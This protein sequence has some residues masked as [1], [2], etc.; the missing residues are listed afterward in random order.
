MSHKLKPVWIRAT[1]RSDNDFH[2]SHEVICCSNL[3]R[4]RVAAIYRI[5]SRPLDLPHTNASA[6]VIKNTEVKHVPRPALIATFTF[7]STNT[8]FKYEYVHHSCR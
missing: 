3:S 8:G 7:T 1:D 2:M 6:S 4:R 5:V